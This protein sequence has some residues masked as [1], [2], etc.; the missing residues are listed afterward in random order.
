M[1][2]P[3]AV[4]LTQQNTLLAA[5]C[6]RQLRKALGKF[7]RTKLFATRVKGGVLSIE[8]TNTGHGWHPHCHLLL[9]ARWLSLTVREPR[10]SDDKATQRKLLRA[11]HEELSATWAATL[12]QAEAVVWVERAWGKAMIETL[13]YAVKP[14]TLLEC[15]E[16]VAPIIREMHRLQLVN[17]FGTFYGVGKKIAA[18]LEALH[19]A[20]PCKSCGEAAGWSTEESIDRGFSKVSFRARATINAERSR[21]FNETFGAYT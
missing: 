5:G 3:L 17:G 2:H 20:Q 6:L 8:V 9:D 14:S 4:T 12:Q 13:K 1:T 7:R 19:E 15:D 10:R 18:E 21:A 16:P 11:A